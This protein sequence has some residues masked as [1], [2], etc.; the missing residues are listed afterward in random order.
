ME[1]ASGGSC[2]RL[3]LVESWGKKFWKRKKKGGFPCKECKVG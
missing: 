1:G 2:E 3:G